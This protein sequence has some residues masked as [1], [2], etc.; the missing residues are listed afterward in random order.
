MNSSRFWTAAA[1]IALAVI[2]GF[3]LS[4]PHTRDA[5]QPMTTQNAVPIPS[6]TVHDDFKKG[7][8]TITGSL[9][10][11]DACTTIAAHASV[12]GTA[13]STEKILIAISM[14]K[15]TEV[16]LH[17]PT[18]ENFSITISAPAHTPITTT[19]NGSST[20]TTVL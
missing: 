6:V 20:S 2:I 11:P 10:V 5:S 14:P 12:T 19:I 15:D 13:S 9:E 17:I 8:H 4:V 16:C 18:T 3:A 7:F 1:I